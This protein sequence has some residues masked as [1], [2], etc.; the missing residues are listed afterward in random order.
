MTRMMTCD[1]ILCYGISVLNLKFSTNINAMTST[2]SQNYGCQPDVVSHLWSLITTYCNPSKSRLEHLFWTL[3]FLKKYEL[4]SSLTNVFKVR[5]NTFRKH[6]VSM[7]NSIR[8]ITNH[9][10]SFKFFFWNKLSLFTL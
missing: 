8:S 9:V 7:L 1:D 6:V 2:F 10:V 3:Y 4:E 5:R